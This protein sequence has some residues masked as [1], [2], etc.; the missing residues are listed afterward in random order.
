[1]VNPEERYDHWRLEHLVLKEVA[2]EA[3]TVVELW[4]SE[5]VHQYQANCLIT[6]QAT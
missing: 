1:M 2:K 5:D 4:Y 6:K 3:K